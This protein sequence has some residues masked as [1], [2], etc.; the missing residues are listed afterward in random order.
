[1]AAC[2]TVIRHELA[3]V[4]ASRRF[5]LLFLAASL[6]I[7]LAV[8]QGGIRLRRQ[9]DERLRLERMAEAEW[10]SQEAKRPHSAHHFGKWVV[11][12][13]SP[14]S[15]FDQGVEAWLG[16]QILLDAHH[17]SDPVAS[18]AEEDPLQAWIGVFDLGFVTAFLL[19]LLVIFLSYDA[20]CGEKERG[21][22]RMVLSH[23][24]PR[25]TFLLG[26]WIAHAAIA[27]SAFGVPL[28]AGILLVPAALG[29]DLGRAELPRLLALLGASLAYLL[30][31]S[32]LSLWVSS[33]THRPATA[34]AWL[35]A[36]W[37]A[38]VFFL[39]RAAVLIAELARPATDP[40]VLGREQA[41]I[42][43][44]VEAW[45]AVRFTEVIRE[46][47]QTW[48]E[49]P[50]DFARSGMSRGERA[51]VDWSVDPTGLF[52]KEANAYL[53]ARRLESIELVRQEHSRQER[54]ATWIA[55]VSPTTSFL[56][57]S[58]TLAGTDLARHRHFEAQVDDY[59][60]RVESFFNAL[61]SRNLQSFD[62]W[63]AAPGFHYVEEPAGAL[64]GRFSVSFG[65][66]G[67][68]CLVA[69]AGSVLRLD[70]YDVR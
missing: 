47:R 42:R 29:V 43:E 2:L 25:R 15:M 62:D 35:F 3:Q 51:P 4:R 60:D 55:R 32:L 52:A 6:L 45:R 65:A 46:L 61:W 66:L 27:V 44:E 39:P 63:E 1:M 48:P 36:A 18:L 64:W 28:A 67:A 38:L 17:R 34:L 69:A 13:P 54:L 5:R 30:F 33:A 58:M 19:P 59:F 21:T 16:Q 24:V 12:P 57:A 50:E 41:R 8:V 11:K 40:V 10:T 7:L 56:D 9:A 37:V 22:L 49:I 31:F 14:L 70:R 53:N 68:F 23:P 26:K 20:V